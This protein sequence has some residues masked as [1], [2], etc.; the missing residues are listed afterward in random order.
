MIIAHETKNGGEKSKTPF[1]SIFFYNCARN[2]WNVEKSQEQGENI[3]QIGLFHRKSNNDCLS[4]SKAARIE[5]GQKTVNIIVGD[6]RYWTKGLSL[7]SQIL[8]ELKDGVNKL[9]DI[10]TNLKKDRTNIRARLNELKG[11]GLVDSPSRGYWEII[12]SKNDVI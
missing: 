7:K 3:I 11:Y 2:I 1:G 9:D 12:E 4:S 5:F 8:N 10:V 6:E